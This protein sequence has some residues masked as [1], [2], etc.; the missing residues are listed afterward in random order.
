MNFKEKREKSNMLFI[1]GGLFAIFLIALILFGKHTFSY[2]FSG[3]TKDANQIIASGEEL[4]KGDMVTLKIYYLTSAYAETKGNFK[5]R[6]SAYHYIAWLEDG[7]LIS[8]SAHDNDTIQKFN[9]F[10]DEI[11][12]YSWGKTATAPAPITIT[13][14][15]HKINSKV[16]KFYNEQV[17]A[18]KYTLNPNTMSMERDESKF[19]KVYNLE[20]DTSYSRSSMKLLS[21]VIILLTVLSGVAFIYI[22]LFYDRDSKIPAEQPVSRAYNTTASN[23]IEND[24][25]FNKSF[26]NTYT[27]KNSD[28]STMEKV[29]KSESDFK[30]DILDDSFDDDYESDNEPKSTGSKFKLKEID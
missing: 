18:A 6:Q 13:G 23:N 30:S 9:K 2:T 19:S 25:I 15:I 29:K 16:K 28:S 1:T 3:K 7:S 21:V 8:I 27:N 24:P 17:D 4:K 11:Y 10:A 5:T 14:N 22:L 12:D 26:Y 20:I